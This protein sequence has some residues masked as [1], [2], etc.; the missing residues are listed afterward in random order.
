MPITVRCGC[1]RVFRAPESL[2]G[3][4]AKCPACGAILL[5][6]GLERVSD[7]STK[8]DVVVR[9]HSCTAAFRAAVHLTGTT[10]ECPRCHSPIC[11]PSRALTV[12]PP[13]ARRSQVLPAAP[14]PTEENLDPQSEPPATKTPGSVRCDRT[15]QLTFGRIIVVGSAGL[16]AAVLLGKMSSLCVAKSSPFYPFFLLPTLTGLGLGHVLGFAIRR[17]HIDRLRLSCS[18]GAVMGLAIL[19]YNTT[20]LMRQAIPSQGA[21][22][23]RTLWVQWRLSTG[24][25]KQLVGPYLHTARRGSGWYSSLRRSLHR[26]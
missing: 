14:R 25:T 2:A 9:C 3:R 18:L 17:A 12:P 24:N 26:S 6:P 5:I 19:P 10:V 22:P 8:V 16:L 13:S 11:V 4:Q 21:R 7:Q 1:N 23:L 15:E 20:S